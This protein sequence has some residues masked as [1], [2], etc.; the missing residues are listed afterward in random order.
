[1]VTLNAQLRF[2]DPD[3]SH[4]QCGNLSPLTSAISKNHHAA[5][6]SFLSPDSLR[7]KGV[8]AKSGRISRKEDWSL[9]SI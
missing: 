3:K 8:E 2:G 9:V 7:I 1:M 5:K 6:I 4:Q